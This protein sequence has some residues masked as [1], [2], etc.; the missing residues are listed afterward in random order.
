MKHQFKLVLFS[1]FI[2]IFAYGQAPRA[3]SLDYS[4]VSMLG[5][6]SA[7]NSE[8]VKGSPYINKVFGHGKVVNAAEN[9]FLRYNAYD[10]LFE[11]ISPN[12]D[13]LVLSK[14]ESYGDILFTGTKINY[15]LVNYTDKNNKLTKGYLI[16][17]H[18]K[19]DFI[20][21][22]K[23]K[24]NYSSARPAV[25]SYAEDLPAEYTIAAEVFY[26]KSKDQEILEFPTSKKGLVKLYPDRKE[27]IETFLKQNKI[28][29]DSEA[30]LKKLIDFLAG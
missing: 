23:Q 15:R 11:F 5:R 28:N 25:S 26:L 2:S 7:K 14:T 21:Y 18:Q 27:A 1:L 24:V 20:L 8:V 12:N 6:K 22:K 9:V 13:T 3:T 16:Q 4:D 10:D 17:L 19:N 30:D 29:F